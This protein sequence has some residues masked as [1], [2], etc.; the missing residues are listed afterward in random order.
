MLERFLALQKA[1]M[2][3]T[4]PTFQN[5]SGS[6]MSLERRK[7]LLDLCKKFKIPV[8][9]DDP[10][11]ELYYGKEPPPSLKSLDS[12]N[13]VIYLSSYTKIM[14]PGLRVGWI[15]APR[16][17][18]ERLAEERRYLD[19]NTNTICQYAINEFCRDGIMQ[20]HLENLRQLYARKRD[21]MLSGLKKH[22]YSF[23]TWN[24]PEGGIFI[25]ARLE[26]NMSSASLLNECYYEKVSFV[27][28]ENFFPDEK[29]DE[30]LRLNFSHESEAK[31]EEGI[32]RLSRALKR[33]NT[34]KRHILR[35]IE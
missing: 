21:V 24:K 34:A 10:Y 30:W 22:C 5:P 13:H 11:S 19:V 1:R 14:F 32:K 4:I 3:Y 27:S 16:Q 31:I 33:L 20:S 6:V 12:H 23:M 17:V 18:I 28:G 8:V 9:E 26:R 7:K 2:I 35:P 25:W 29:G 15:I